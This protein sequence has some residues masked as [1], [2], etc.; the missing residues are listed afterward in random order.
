MNRHRTL[1][2]WLRVDLLVLLGLWLVAGTV[3]PGVLSRSFAK[4]TQSIPVTHQRAQ[5]SPASRRGTRYW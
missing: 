5:S 2:N 4:V 3:L 1:T